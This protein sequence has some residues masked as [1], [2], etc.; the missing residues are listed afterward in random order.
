MG[1]I[2]SADQELDRSNYDL[3]FPTFVHLLIVY[4][5][6]RHTGGGHK[7]PQIVVYLLVRQNFSLWDMIIVHT[8]GPT[9]VDSK[10]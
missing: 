6:I 7:N 10:H 5:W 8:N 2:Q 9:G 1:N 3:V 4:T